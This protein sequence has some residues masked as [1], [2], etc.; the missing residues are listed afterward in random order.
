MECS[1]KSTKLQR[2]F[3]RLSGKEGEKIGGR[4]KKKTDIDLC[5]PRKIMAAFQE[6]EKKRRKNASKNVRFPSLLL[7]TFV[8]DILNAPAIL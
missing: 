3:M 7:Q 5:K 6:Q 1:Y 2:L 8:F 4:K